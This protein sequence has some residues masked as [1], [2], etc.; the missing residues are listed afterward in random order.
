MARGLRSEIPSAT[1]LNLP[2][3][4]RKLT[5]SLAEVM[6]HSLRHSPNSL[7]RGHPSH[8]VDVNTRINQ[9]PAYSLWSGDS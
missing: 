8:F 5:N 6:K 2:T 4:K 3:E 1:F 7:E 9:I